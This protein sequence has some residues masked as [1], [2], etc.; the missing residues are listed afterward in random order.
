[1][2]YISLDDKAI[3]LIGEPGLP[4]SSGVRGHNQSI[5]LADGPSPSAFIHGIVPSVAF[6]IKIPESAQDSE[7]H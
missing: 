4:V 2:S 3:I 6:T 5:V 1:V 7:E